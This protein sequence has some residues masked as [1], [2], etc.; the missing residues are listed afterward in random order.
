MIFTLENYNKKD[1]YKMFNENNLTFKRVCEDIVSKETL[2]ILEKY[3]CIDKIQKLLDEHGTIPYDLFDIA[4]FFK[5]VV[6]VRI[7][8]DDIEIT[9][10]D[11]PCN[12]M[13]FIDFSFNSFTESNKKLEEYV[14]RFNILCE[15]VLTGFYNENKS[16]FVLLLNGSIDID[17]YAEMRELFNKY[18][19]RN[20]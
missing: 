20:N 10:N 16:D 13:V 11:I 7:I 8:K 4:S 9:I 17:N 12:Q 6:V 2:D 19:K 15:N 5:D 18:Y 14:N 1:V 3:Q